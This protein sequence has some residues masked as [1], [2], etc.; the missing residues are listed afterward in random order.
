MR[1]PDYSLCPSL[2]SQSRFYPVFAPVTDSYLPVGERLIPEDPERLLRLRNFAKVP[3]L[4]GLDHD[5]GLVML[6]KLVM[7]GVNFRVRFVCN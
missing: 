6:C 1:R 3:L 2:Q 7:F 5:D 4:A